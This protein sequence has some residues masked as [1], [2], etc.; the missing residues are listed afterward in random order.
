[1][2]ELAKRGDIQ[3]QQ[4][5]VTWIGALSKPVKKSRDELGKQNKTDKFI[6]DLSDGSFDLSSLDSLDV[7][8]DIFGGFSYDFSRSNDLY[9][10][11]SQNVIKILTAAK[12]KGAYEA[13]YKLYKSEHGSVDDKLIGPMAV[14]GK[15]RDIDRLLKFSKSNKVH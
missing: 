3:A 9:S 7:P 5:L 12:A 4:K 1:M 6:D 11:E 2:T 13:F 15:K 10:L 14:L 8:D